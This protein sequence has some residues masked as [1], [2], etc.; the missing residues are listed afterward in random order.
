MNWFVGSTF[1]IWFNFLK[2]NKN[3][4]MP[5]N[6]IKI[7]F[8]SLFTLRNTFISKKEF[9]LLK[10]QN[11]P[12]FK[13][14]DPI[15]ILGHWRSGTTHLQN[16]LINDKNF[17]YPTLLQ[18]TFPNTFLVIQEKLKSKKKKMENKR[19]MDNMKINPKSPGE[20]EVA[21]W[22]MCNISPIGSR[23][24]K[25][26]ESYYDRF[27]T[28]EDATKQ[29]YE[30]WENSL[31]TF[32]SKVSGNDTRPLLLKS[33]EH[34]ARIKILLNIFPNAKFIHLHRNPLDVFQSTKHLFDKVIRPSYYHK[35]DDEHLT[36][37]IISVYRKMYDS[38]FEDIKLLNKNNFIDISYENLIEAPVE[39]IRN[40]YTQLNL[41]LTDETLSKIEN[42]LNSV[43][44]YKQNKYSPLNDELKTKIRE[45]W[46]SSFKYWGY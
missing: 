4:W 42:Y 9:I 6:W 14:E 10:K 16:I 35:V 23:L 44:S 12:N 5:Q 2:E 27:L 28:F 39:V 25:N 24:L 20:D 18:V 43:K 41:V 7:I 40:I 13:L 32:L 31:L 29:E 1:D 36:N 30:I 8:T 46:N 17:N 34:T 21:V 22:S 45:E 33:P 15:F 11:H 37:R 19:P 26:K 38:F 3:V